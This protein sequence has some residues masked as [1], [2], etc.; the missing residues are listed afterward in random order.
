MPLGMLASGPT[1]PSCPHFESLQ[2][3]SQFPAIILSPSVNYRTLTALDLHPS[4]PH[5]SSIEPFLAAV[6]SPYP[7]RFAQQRPGPFSPYFRQ[8]SQ[9]LCGL[10]G[11]AWSLFLRLSFHSL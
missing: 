6:S 8:L 1:L 3:L 11:A 9:K 4:T 2:I 7:L 10:A 5:S